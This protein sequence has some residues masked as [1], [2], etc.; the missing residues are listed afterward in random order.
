[1]N[2]P[3][4]RE[5]LEQWRAWLKWSLAFDAD[6]SLGNEVAD[7][8]EAALAAKEKAEKALDGR[9]G[10][11][12]GAVAAACEQYVKAEDALPDRFDTED[13]S[14]SSAVKRVVD[15][16]EFLLHEI[17]VAATM[18]EDGKLQMINELIRRFP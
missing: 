14:L 12:P 7:R 16:L 17:H 6:Y 8:F 18:S 10:D 13:Y 2:E 5:I 11:I 1:M 9:L 3:T 15:Y 4:D